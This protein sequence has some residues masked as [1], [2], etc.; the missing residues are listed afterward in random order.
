[1]TEETT[2]QL[3]QRLLEISGL[4]YLAGR[5]Q[6]LEKFLPKKAK[7]TPL[8]VWDEPFE[9]AVRFFEQKGTMLKQDFED[10]LDEI[11]AK[12]FTVA[13]LENEH[14]IAR[15]QGK[16]KLALEKGI[17]VDEFRDEMET[18]FD[19]LGVGLLE[20]WHTELVY[21]QNLQNSFHAGFF[22]AINDP[23]VATEFPYLRYVTM[24]DSRVRPTHAAMHGIIF[25]RDGIG[26]W[27]PP[28]GFR[29]RCTVIPITAEQ[30]GREGI[31][32]SE[33]PK[34]IRDKA[35]R[36]Q[37]VIPDEGFQA[38]PSEGLRGIPE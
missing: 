30:A 22:E 7:D 13:R 27:Y 14:L 3:G 36:L 23:D 28:N 18:M 11:K 38:N 6:M 17:T 4:G 19:R 1:M 20:T 24:D 34:F 25:T 29:C 26:S 21:H 35:G 33:Q 8:T 10:L 32:P 12:W 9:Q 5:D 16:V 15:V 31:E 2:E 37:P